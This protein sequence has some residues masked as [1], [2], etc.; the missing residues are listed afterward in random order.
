MSASKRTRARSIQTVERQRG[1]LLQR[2]AVVHV[3]NL[4]RSLGGGL[5]GHATLYVCTMLGG[6][7]ARAYGPVCCFYMSTEWARAAPFF[8]RTR[9]THPQIMRA[10]L[11]RPNVYTFSA[12]HTLHIHL[13]T[14]T[15]TIAFGKLFVNWIECGGNDPHMTNVCRT[16]DRP[17][18]RRLSNVEFTGS[19]SDCILFATKFDED[20]VPI[21]LKT[22]ICHFQLNFILGEC[23]YR[24]L[25]SGDGARGEVINWH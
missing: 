11:R 15:N 7:H 17:N 25:L 14:N 19:V 16:F 22:Q 5:F 9:K 20:I 2:G 13:H 21:K 3:I 10:S 6:G 18:C 24:Y 23:N 1:I 4:W 12:G 8:R